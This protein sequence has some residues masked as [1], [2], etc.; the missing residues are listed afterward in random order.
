MIIWISE[1]QSSWL[2]CRCVR[3]SCD[4]SHTAFTGAHCET[5]V[6]PCH[7]EPCFNSAT[8]KD[9]RGN[10]TC[11]C[12]PGESKH[13]TLRIKTRWEWEMSLQS[14]FNHGSHAAIMKQRIIFVLTVLP[15][16]YCVYRI[17]SGHSDSVC[18]PR[19]TSYTGGRSIPRVVPIWNTLCVLVSGF[20]GHQC[21]ID[22]SECSSGP[23]A[24]GGHC[25]ERS[26]RALYGSEPLLPE[27]Y[28]QQ[29][30]AGYICSCP[31]GTTGNSF[32]VHKSLMR[33]IQYFQV[34]Y[35]GTCVFNSDV[36]I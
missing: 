25:I 31:P 18:Y 3:Y 11:E 12:W 35:A 21:E 17:C 1:S 27:H 29:H 19:R 13:E 15:R 6:P 10:Y 14:V 4:C 30:A 28:D 9:G 22:V 36:D 20:E 23:C 34:Q 26:W 33:N 24:H 8:C 2:L 32:T 5:P 7:S 16:L